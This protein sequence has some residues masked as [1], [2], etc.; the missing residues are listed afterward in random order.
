MLICVIISSRIVKI[1]ILIFILLCILV[2]DVISIMK[3]SKYN[4]YF[5]AE[6]G[7]KLAFN[8]YSCG[9]AVVDDTYEALISQID[10]ITPDNVPAD[11][12]ECYEA[13]IA[14]HFI[15]DDDYDELAELSVKRNLQKYGTDSLGLTIAPTL[16]CNFKCIYCYETSKPGVMS[17]E[18]C[19]HI[20]RYVENQSG[21]LNHLSVSWYG[22]EPLLAQ[23]IIWRLS[24]DF[25]N[26]C[27]AHEIEYDAFMI[28]NGSL[29]NDEVI[30]QMIKYKISGIQITI[31]GPPE[32]HNKR[33][34]NKNGNDTFDLLIENINRLLATEKIEVVVRINVDKTNKL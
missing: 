28:S 25:I 18:V 5:T 23:D 12:L 29:I 30:R 33:R 22:G 34:V 32:V 26:I 16:A 24:D 7:S 9:L 13:A 2:K 14:G 15:I 19:D 31:D 4:M 8:S 17:F 20:V 27:E 10:K 11:L 3:Q 1:I 21:R 6:D